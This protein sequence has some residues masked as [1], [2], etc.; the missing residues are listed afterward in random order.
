MCVLNKHVNK[1]VAKEKISMTFT[2]HSINQWQNVWSH[3]EKSAKAQ[4]ST[5]RS[6]GNARELWQLTSFAARAKMTFFEV[7]LTTWAL[8]N[9]NFGIGSLLHDLIL[10]TTIMKFQLSIFR[11][12]VCTECIASNWQS[13]LL[14]NVEKNE[15]NSCLHSL[16]WVT[17]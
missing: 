1:N 16:C 6:F 15:K 13:W 3:S 5:S 4:H 11:I 17:N 9:Q 12:C 10:S 7:S 14:K 8:T 2:R